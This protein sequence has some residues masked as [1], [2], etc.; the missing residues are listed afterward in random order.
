MRTK[1][2]KKKFAAVLAL[3]MLSWA[4][5]V[6]G[7]P[8]FAAVSED[9]VVCARQGAQAAGDAGAPMSQSNQAVF[10]TEANPTAK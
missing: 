1:K 4:L 7:P 8:A 6:G 10:R 9:V 3:A 5:M 2:K